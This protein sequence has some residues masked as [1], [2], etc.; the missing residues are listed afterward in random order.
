MAPAFQPIAVAGLLDIGRPTGTDSGSPA[1]ASSRPPPCRRPCGGSASAMRRVLVEEDVPVRIA[2]EQRRHACGDVG[3]HLAPSCRP[4]RPCTRLCPGVWPGVAT[5]V[6]PGATSLPALVLRDLAPSA[7][8]TV[9]V[10]AN[11]SFMRAARAAAHLAVVHDRTSTPPPAPGFRR[12]G[13]PACC[14]A[15]I[16]PLMWSPWK[17]EMMTMST[18]L[19]SMPAAFRLLWNWPLA[20]LLRSKLASPE[21]GVD[22]DELGAGVDDDRRVRDRHHVLFHVSGSSSASFT[23]VL[24]GVER[25]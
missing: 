7:S 18:A 16:R 5:E 4:R 25:R 13:R 20:P 2:R 3:L 11:T 15:L 8:N 6:M 12:W 9:R 17:C 1:P 14:P 24:L 21:A 23:S 22:D 19:R 10:P